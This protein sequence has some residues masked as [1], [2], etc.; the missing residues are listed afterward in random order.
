[1]FNAKPKQYEIHIRTH[2]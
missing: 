2:M 1:M